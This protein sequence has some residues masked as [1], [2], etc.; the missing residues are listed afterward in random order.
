[1]LILEY[2]PGVELFDAILSKSSFSEDEAR[3]VFVQARKDSHRSS[4]YLCMQNS[5]CLK[6]CR[7]PCVCDTMNSATLSSNTSGVSNVS[8]VFCW[9]MLG[10][11]SAPYIYSLAEELRFV[12]GRFSLGFFFNLGGG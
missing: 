1:M 10:F 7:Q 4:V 2:A 3:P 9:M 11:F 8:H 12:R 6:D 5:C